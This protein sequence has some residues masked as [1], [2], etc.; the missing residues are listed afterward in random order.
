MDSALLAPTSVPPSWPPSLQVLLGEP[1]PEMWSAVLG[2]RSGRLRSLVATTVTL[3]PDG[4]ATVR[5]TAVVDWADGRATRESLAA[6]TGAA[7][8][9]GAAVL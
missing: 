7:V 4:A 5:Y 9:P 2:P 6:T 8:P 1:A 3:R